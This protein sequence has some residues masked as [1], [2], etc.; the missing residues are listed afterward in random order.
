MSD[1]PTKTKTHKLNALLGPNGE[2][3]VSSSEAEADW[4][5]D[6][7]EGWDCDECDIRKAVVTITVPVLGVPTVRLVGAIEVEA[8]RD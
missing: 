3:I 2:I 5:W 1:Q 8:T 4:L 6:A 7:T